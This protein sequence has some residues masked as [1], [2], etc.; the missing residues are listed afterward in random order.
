MC[1]SRSITPSRSTHQK[2][3]CSPSRNS[4]VPGSAL[5][6]SLTS[7]S[8]P[9]CSAV[10]PSNR[11]SA[12]SSARIASSV[13]NR[14][15]A[16]IPRIIGTSAAVGL[17]RSASGTRSRP[18]Q[19]VYSAGVW[20]AGPASADIGACSG[21][22]HAAMC[23]CSLNGLQRRLHLRA[24]LLGERATSPESAAGRRVNRA[25]Q[26]TGDPRL[27]LRLLSDRVGD[28]RGVDEAPRVGVRR[29]WR[30]TSSAGPTSTSLPRYMT[31]MWSDR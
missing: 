6:S 19:E 7:T 22:W 25:R 8:S 29:G 20:M 23:P 2:S 3:A 5:T 26:L 13:M 17:G 9:S 31:P 10:R 4:S 24:D 12:R 15:Y 21:K 16:D 18:S 28:R 30:Y 11:L 27:D 1:R 14:A